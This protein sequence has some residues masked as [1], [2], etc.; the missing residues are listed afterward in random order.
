MTVDLPN[1]ETR[2]ARCMCAQCLSN[3]EEAARR[4]LEA[5][6]L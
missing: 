3:R 2:P 6:A 5:G 4:R 1:G